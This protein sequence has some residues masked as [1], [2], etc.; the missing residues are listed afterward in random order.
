MLRC[1]SDGNT[2]FLKTRPICSRLVCRPSL[3]RETATGQPLLVDGHEGVFAGQDDRM[4]LALAFAVGIDALGEQRAGFIAKRTGV[5]QGKRRTV[6]EG[7]ALS[8]AKPR[9]AEV[10]SLGA[11][12]GNVEI[13][14]VEVG[15]RV[16]LADALGLPG[17]E[18]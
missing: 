12:G 16:W 14:A 2:S 18:V 8:L 11:D 5:L 3:Q 17:H 1:R 6:A 10:P 13:E 4:P 7:D 9:I 15:Q